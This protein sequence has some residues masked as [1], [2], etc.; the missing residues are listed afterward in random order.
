MH[1]G[2]STTGKMLSVGG[3][4]A[5]LLTASS[6][7]CR[8]RKQLTRVLTKL[9]NS[10]HHRRSCRPV[11][12]PTPFKFLT[13]LALSAPP[14]PLLFP[15]SLPPP[16][17]PKSSSEGLQCQQQPFLWSPLS[18]PSSLTCVGPHQSCVAERVSARIN[19][20]PPLASRIGKS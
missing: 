20:S 9:C 8:E 6:E 17:S 16:L 7:T 15:P 10:V 5:P 12:M 19:P 2:T 18:F 11:A 1:V 4:I 3:V 13:V 14:P